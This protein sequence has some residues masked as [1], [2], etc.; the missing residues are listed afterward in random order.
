MRFRC[1]RPPASPKSI[2]QM[3]LV[4]Q[5]GI[6]GGTSASTCLM[7]KKQA[8]FPLAEKHDPLTLCITSTTANG[9]VVQPW[10]SA[11]ELNKLGDSIIGTRE[12]VLACLR[13]QSAIQVRLRKKRTIA[14]GHLRRLGFVVIASLRFKSVVDNACGVCSDLDQP[15]ILWPGGCGHLFCQT[16]T[17]GC[18]VR[19]RR[20]PLCRMPAPWR[21]ADDWVVTALQVKPSRQIGHLTHSSQS[22]LP[23]THMAPTVLPQ[24]VRPTQHI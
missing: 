5:D 12:Q 24:P 23:T 15:T 10:R 6:D 3:L 11:S 20:C 22:K 8:P 17:Q 18:L 9:S 19:S 16:C 14:R 7:H 13:L 2:A 4:P 1:C 21:L